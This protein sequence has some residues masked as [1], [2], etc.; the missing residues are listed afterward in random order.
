MGKLKSAARLTKKA[1]VITGK[2]TLKTAKFAGETTLRSAKIIR[3]VDRAL[4]SRAV[5]NA[6]YSGK[7]Y[8]KQQLS[9]SGDAG[10]ATVT[11]GSAVMEFQRRTKRHMQQ[12]KAYYGERKFNVRKLRFQ[13]TLGTKA[14]YRYQ[15][16]YYKKVSANSKSVLKNEAHLHKEFVQK[17]RAT[18]KRLETRAPKRMVRAQKKFLKAEKKSYKKFKKTTK[19]LVRSEKNLLKQRKRLKKLTKPKGDTGGLILHSVKQQLRNEAMKDAADN[20][21]IQ[22]AQKLH[23]IQKAVAPKKSELQKQQQRAKKLKKKTGQRKVQLHTRESKLHHKKKRKRN[24]PAN[25]QKRRRYPG[26]HKTFGGWIASGLRSGAGAIKGLAGKVLIAVA[27][28]ILLGCLLYVF[29]LPL[30]FVDSVGGRSSFVMGT[31]SALDSDLSEAVEYYTELAYKAN[32]AVIKCGTSNWKDGLRYFDV[33]GSTLRSYKEDPDT[34]KF[35]DSAYDF[36]YWK[37]YSFLCAYY[38][39]YDEDEQMIPYWEYGGKTEKVIKQLFE[40]EYAFEYE[41]ENGS[42][43][44]RRDHYDFRQNKDTFTRA[45]PCIRETDTEEW[46]VFEFDF[47]PSGLGEYALVVDGKYRVYYDLE[48]LEVLNANDGK[49]ETGWYFLDQTGTVTDA[50]GDYR[51]GFY[52]KNRY[53]NYGGDYGIYVDCG[54]DRFWFPRTTI[55]S[56]EDLPAAVSPRDAVLWLYSFSSA[57]DPDTGATISSFYNSL[58]HAYT[59]FIPTP[60]KLNWNRNG[61]YSSILEKA[62]AWDSYSGFGYC[63]WY[64]KYDWVKECRLTYTMKQKMSFDNAIK[65]MLNEKDDSGTLYE[66]YLLLVGDGDDSGIVYGNHQTLATPVT[67]GLVKLEE[68]N[69][70]VNGYGWDMQGWNKKHCELTMHNGVDI[71]RN[72]GSAVYAMFDGKITDAKD[73]HVTLTTNGEKVNLWYDDEHHLKVTYSNINP[74]VH[75][76]DTVKAGEIIGYS[77]GAKRCYTMPN[78]STGCDY[79]HISLSV[80]YASGLLSLS[81]EWRTVDPR[82]L[83]GLDNH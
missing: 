19:K 17:Q 52:W 12:R 58:I 29:V 75:D 5:T 62:E 54:D 16:L 10:Q 77:T 59:K 53:G 60:N 27:P 6:L 39:E 26:G 73:G 30:L 81:T 7:E 50:T 80:E 14:E 61:F 45:Y 65:A 76:N 32:E 83:I 22:G 25:R 47:E 35:V 46:G 31:Y 13:R 71:V 66:Y 11:A 43:W 36:D 41:Y 3:K 15:K 74:T 2:A 23:S 44:R 8:T 34:F 48:S 21:F 78:Q 1:V 33:S 55:Y 4:T 9:G 82:L 28:F 70:F 56:D 64:K 42:H 69:Y 51:S 24:T 38:Y 72:S 63:S 67:Q 37:F 49:S 40:K 79:V 68:Y 57:A 20:E 18:L